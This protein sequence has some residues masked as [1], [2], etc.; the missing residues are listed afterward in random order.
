MWGDN[1][2]YSLCDVKEGCREL[3]LESILRFEDMGK[4]FLKLKFFFPDSSKTSCFKNEF[5]IIN[6]IL[7]NFLH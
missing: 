5:L 6:K 3:E 2:V 4:R 1:L 7:L